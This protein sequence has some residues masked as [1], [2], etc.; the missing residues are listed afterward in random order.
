MGHAQLVAEVTGQ[1]LSLFQ[2]DPKVIKKRIEDLITRE[3]LERAPDSN[4]TYNYLA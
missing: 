3:Y 4:N 1:L 2:P